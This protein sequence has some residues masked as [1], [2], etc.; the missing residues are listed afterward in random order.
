[1]QRKTI[2]IL[3]A[4]FILA[5]AFFSCSE[6]NT[7][8]TAD[9]K[10]FRETQEQLK[11][12]LNEANLSPK[13]RWAIVNRIANNLYTAGKSNEMVLFLTEWV[14]NHPDD[15]YNAYWLL[16]VA[17][18]YL[19]KGAVPVAEYYFD[20]ILQNYR[21]LYVQGKSIHFMCLEHLIQVSKTPAHRISYFN[22]LVSR[23]PSNVSITEMYV[24][25]AQEYEKEGEWREA[26]KSY[27]MFL[28]QPDAS[29]IQIPGISD[30]YSSAKKMVDFDKSSKDWTFE[31]L[32]SL[33]TSVKKAIKNYDWKSLDR[34]RSK[35]NF[36]AMSWKT[37]ETASNALEN[38]SMRNYMV[39]QRIRYSEKLDETSNPNEAYLRSTGWTPYMPV[40][41]LY[42]RKINFPADPDI[43]G[44]WEW[45][46]I[47][48][49]EKI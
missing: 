27:S 31:S 28:A 33:E 29:T 4:A 39:G 44:R 32:E 24:R 3:T 6:K 45:A 25:L 36:F 43:H 11:K 14:E 30:A 2:L 35:V 21:D 7:S 37:N 40:W 22:Q 16:M 17:S 42:F 8:Y 23:F 38:F 26:L 49:G 19:D 9:T 13:T 12:H 48:F 1:M 15:T 41:Y 18:D 46:G 5:A 47:Y 10:T 34:Y 20:R